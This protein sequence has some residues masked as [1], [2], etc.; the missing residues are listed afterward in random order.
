MNLTF[1]YINQLSDRNPRLLWLI[2]LILL[3]IL[4]V[5]GLWPFN[6]NARNKVTWLKSQNGVHFYGQGIIV[7][8]DIRNQGQTSPFSEKSIT[9]EIWLR[10]LLETTNLPNILTLFDGKSPELFLVGQWK[11]HLV[12]RSRWEDPVA[13]IRDKPYRE[14]GFQNGL[15]KNQDTFITIT[16]GT[17]GTAVYVNG[18]RIRTYA[19]YNMLADVSE[20]P[21]RFILGNSATGESFWIG[22]LMG[23]AVYNRV[24][25]ATQIFK[26]HQAW[27]GEAPP[28]VPAD[29]RCLGMYR[30]D[31]RK[32]ATIHNMAA[33][34]D[35]LFIP[36]VFEPVQRRFLASLRQGFRWN[37]S[38]V[39]DVIINVIGFIPFGFSLS[40]LLLKT[41][42]PRRLS[43][44]FAVVV[45]GVGLS[46]AIEVSQAYLP[47]RDSSMT[48]VVM[49][50]IGTIL[51]VAIY[52]INKT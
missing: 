48:D 27:T 4:L 46:L 12:I 26:S 51:G 25:S 28:F 11:S 47:S 35:T 45:L 30:F 38:Y 16:S 10:P 37:Y 36:E 31:E 40:A 34:N 39:Q 17:G 8:P 18:K 33:S 41:I 5:A 49:N 32:G 22:N 20:K 24:L 52:Q 44:C 9:L 1:G 6:F 23:F 21:L 50:A 19:N 7:G 13:R 15:L 14:I 43:T 29:D 42:R 2:C 3:V